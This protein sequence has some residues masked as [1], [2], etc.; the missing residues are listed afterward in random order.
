M[1]IQALAQEKTE[2]QDWKVIPIL[3]GERALYSGFLIPRET[4]ENL[5]AYRQLYHEQKDAMA[6]MANAQSGVSIGI[7][8]IFIGFSVGVLFGLLVSNIKK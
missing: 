8:G 3:Y 1:S 4:L 2:N 7:D 6:G 5:E